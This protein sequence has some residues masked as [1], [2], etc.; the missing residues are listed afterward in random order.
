[1]HRGKIKDVERTIATEVL[2]NRIAKVAADVLHAF[3]GEPRSSYIE[4]EKPL[5]GA[6]LN[7]APQK[8]TAD[9]S[10]AAENNCTSSLH[11]CSS[12][13]VTRSTLRSERLVLQD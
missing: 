4:A 3:V 11:A 9:K 6:Q 2:G 7:H 8:M 13:A 1:M 5:I 10:S 12:S